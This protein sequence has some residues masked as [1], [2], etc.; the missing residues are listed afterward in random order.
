MNVTKVWD[1][2][3]VTT[4]QRFSNSEQ[5]R[6]MGDRESRL[7]DVPVA[8]EAAHEARARVVRLAHRVRRRAGHAV[9][10]APEAH[11]ARGEQEEDERHEREPEPG[12]RVR[13]VVDVAQLVL[14]VRVERDVDRECDERDERRER[15]D[16]RGEEG[17]GDVRGEGEEEGDEGHAS[18]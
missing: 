17:H 7:D 12:A 5:K 15:G 16:E 6:W 14:D 8:P 10:A 13:V 4:R 9:A 3:I 11:G 1:V 2:G 18:G